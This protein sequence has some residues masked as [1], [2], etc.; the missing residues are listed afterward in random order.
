MEDNII[1]MNII[2]IKE[3]GWCPAAPA[4]NAKQWVVTQPG[5]TGWQVRSQSR[6]V[7]SAGES[8]AG[9]CK[10]HLKMT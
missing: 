4:Q 2:P 6:P 5:N 3:G 10:M 7:G 8:V 9:F 1:T